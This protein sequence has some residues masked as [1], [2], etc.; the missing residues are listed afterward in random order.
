MKTYFVVGKNDSGYE[1][2]FTINAKS[3]DEVK[4]LVQKRRPGFVVHYIHPDYEGEYDE[5]A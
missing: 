5:Q 3:I 4:G 1:D 2:E